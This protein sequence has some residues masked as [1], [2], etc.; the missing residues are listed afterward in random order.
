MGKD[1]PGEMNGAFIFY[2]SLYK[3]KPKSQMAEIWLMEHGCFDNDKQ[4]KLAKKYKRTQSPKKAAPKKR[5]RKVESDDE[6]SEPKKKK[7]KTDKKKKTKTKTK[8]KRKS[9]S[10]KKKKAMDDDV[11]SASS[12]EGGDDSDWR[13]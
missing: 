9:K 12:D 11:I 2:D 4:L 10:K 3:E 1:T 5:K 13:P 8:S 6:D 7:K